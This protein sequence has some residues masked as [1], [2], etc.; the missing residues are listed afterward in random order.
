M[1][2]SFQRQ[3][4]KGLRIPLAAVLADK[5]ALNSSKSIVPD[6]SLSGQRGGGLVAGKP[7]EPDSHVKHLE[8]KLVVCIGL[9]DEYRFARKDP[10]G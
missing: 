2:T 7:G 1:S 4:Q 6:A 9:G 5:T 8:S 3:C 10:I